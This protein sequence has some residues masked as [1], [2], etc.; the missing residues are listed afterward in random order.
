MGRSY[1]IDSNILWNV[2]ED[3]PFNAN[4]YVSSLVGK[5]DN[6]DYLFRGYY[7]NGRRPMFE[8]IENDT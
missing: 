5:V 1:W 2:E 8:R 7:T 3:F 6:D 4:E